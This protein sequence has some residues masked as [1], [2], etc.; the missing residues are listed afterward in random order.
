MKTLMVAIVL[1]SLMTPLFGLQDTP[2]NRAELADRLIRTFP[3]QDWWVS[4]ERTMQNV[5]ND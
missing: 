2:E 1:A 4:A 3:I 5:P